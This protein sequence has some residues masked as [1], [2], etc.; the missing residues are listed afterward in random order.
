MWG[1]FYNSL[2]CQQLNPFKIQDHYIKSRKWLFLEEPP[3][4]VRMVDIWEKFV[5]SLS[6][7]PSA[8]IYFSVSRVFAQGKPFK[9]LALSFP[10]C[11]E[12]N[13]DTPEKN[14]YVLA[15]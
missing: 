7:V 9:L 3:N 12:G 14:V 2:H 5:F 13:S 11:K 4:F 6:L 8:Q 15:C 1:L 10:D